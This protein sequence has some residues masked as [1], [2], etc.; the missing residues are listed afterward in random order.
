MTHRHGAVG[1]EADGAVVQRQPA[2]VQLLLGHDTEAV[3]RRRPQ[4][5]PWR[6]RG[7]LRKS[8][9]DST[10]WNVTQISFCCYA[11]HDVTNCSHAWCL[12]SKLSP[13]MR[14]AGTA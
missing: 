6:R 2:A 4:P 7:Q 12:Y 8:C 11:G 5:R 13:G 9:T 10:G 14:H 3:L 1:R